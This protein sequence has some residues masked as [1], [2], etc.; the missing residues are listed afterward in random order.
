MVAVQPVAASERIDAIDVIR[1]FALFGVLWMNLYEHAGLTMP[2]DAVADLP[3]A[4]VDRW[5]AVASQWLMQGKAQALF[6][7]LFGFGFAN[8]MTRLEARGVP[9]T[10]FL[11]RIGVLLVFGTIDMLMLWVGDI[12]F[13]YALMGFVL[14]FTRHWSTRMLLLVGLPVAV[15]GMPLLQ[16]VVQLVF[17]GEMYW[18]PSWDEGAEI[19]GTLFLGAD[20]PAYVSELVRAAWVEW[21]S[22]PA[23]TAYLMQIL[24]RFLLGS[25]LYRQGWLSDVAA[26]R[27][28]FV[29]VAMVALPLGLVLSGYSTAVAW[30]DIAPG[31]TGYTVNQLAT[32]IQAAGYGAGIVL[33][34][35]AGRMGLLA[36]GLRAVG[37]T[38]LSNY[39]AQSLFYL[40]VIYGFGLGLMPWLGATLSLA[41]AVVF[42]TVQMVWSHWW[43]KHYRFGPLEWLWRCL[44]YGERF[45]L[46]R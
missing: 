12:L 2:Y 7:L 25:W 20:Y 16:V 14:Y 24:G 3:T 21:W 13:A 9:S 38:A 42:Y 4:Q 40:F 5:V 33:V 32:L 30:F 23:I 10:V 17:N 8:I 19:R 26:H 37:R 1:G 39:I 18:L 28:L 11:R 31:W 6:S 29:K 27:A 41:L 46:K 34:L 44:T 43:L 22:T 15:L 45:P 35:L 36:K